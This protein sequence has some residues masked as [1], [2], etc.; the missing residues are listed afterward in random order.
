MR[1]RIAWE[2]G[3]RRTRDDSETP[4]TGFHDAVIEA[5]YL[6]ALPVYKMRPWHG[7]VALY[8]PPLE[9]RWTVS[10]GRGVNHERQYVYPDNDWGRYAPALS[11]T[12][13]PGDHDSMV[14][15][16]NVRVLA[17]YM[18]DAINTVEANASVKPRRSVDQA[19]E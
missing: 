3:K 5:A 12:E 4:Q 15:E 18:R 11:V 16:P 10:G 13:V 1:D 6:A 14:L 9:R 17:T 7:R 8:R 19:A 2:I